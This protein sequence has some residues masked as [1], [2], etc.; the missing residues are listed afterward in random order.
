MKGHRQ[1]MLGASARHY[2]VKAG[3]GNG[4][5]LK[6]NLNQKTGKYAKLIHVLADPDFLKQH[7]EAKGRGQGY[8][9]SAVDQETVDGIKNE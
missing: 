4:S 2:G 3:G 9:T 1:G 8:M 7:Y 6:T 5:F